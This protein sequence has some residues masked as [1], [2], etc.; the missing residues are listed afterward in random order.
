MIMILKLKKLY[1]VT[2]SFNPIAGIDLWLPNFH[3]EQILA[4]ASESKQFS[5]LHLD[6]KQTNASFSLIVKFLI[7]MNALKKTVE[8]QFHSTVP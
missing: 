2:Y 1:W 3:W 5:R 6:S 7:L 4:I 8:G